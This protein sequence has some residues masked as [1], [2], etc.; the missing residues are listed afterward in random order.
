MGG[1]S[2]RMAT[3]LNDAEDEEGQDCTGRTRRR[4]DTPRE[5]R[6]GDD[7]TKASMLE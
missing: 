1:I 6:M 3:F 2:G 4:A 5:G 7:F